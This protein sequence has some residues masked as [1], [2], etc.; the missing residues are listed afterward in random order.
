MIDNFLSIM[1]KGGKIVTAAMVRTLDEIRYVLF[2]VD[3]NRETDL[4]RIW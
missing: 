4:T 2:V 1:K 3:L